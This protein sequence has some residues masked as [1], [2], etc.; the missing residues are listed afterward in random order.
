MF[1]LLTNRNRQKF[2]VASP[3]TSPVKVPSLT[4]PNGTYLPSVNVGGP[5]PPPV[6]T[7]TAAIGPTGA[8]GSGLPKPPAPSS[9]V[10]PT[11][12]NSQTIVG[13]NA[14]TV[15]APTSTRFDEEIAKPRVIQ[16][17]R[18]GDPAF[19]A[20]QQGVINAEA[21]ITRFI[22]AAETTG[23]MDFSMLPSQMNIMTIRGLGLDASDLAELGYVQDPKTLNW[24]NQNKP[25]AAPQQTQQPSEEFMSTGFMQ[26][27]TEN[28]VAFE[29][30]LRWDPVKKKY[31]KIG[32]IQADYGYLP[33]E[34]SKEERRK[35]F[36]REE[37]QRRA[38]E[39]Q[40]VTQEPSSGTNYSSGTSSGS[41]NTATG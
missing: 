23:Q 38:A 11:W 17:E 27:N 12:N 10:P 22:L 15:N 18:R 5:H 3:S 7:P 33:K 13:Q 20:L 32:Q 39:Q 16:P 30:Q 28:N 1:P 14:M 26:S 36:Q 19:R 34:Q 29:N 37:R 4:F 40:R 2:K 21:D 41:F 6:S 35:Q 9:S 24:V 8:F 31:R 25:G